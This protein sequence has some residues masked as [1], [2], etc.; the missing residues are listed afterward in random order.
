MCLD[1]VDRLTMRSRR[2]LFGLGASPLLLGVGS[3]CPPGDHPLPAHRV[4]GGGARGEQVAGAV[5]ILAALAA[6]ILLFR[7][8]LRDTLFSEQAQAHLALGTRDCLRYM[9]V[10]KTKL[11]WRLSV[12]PSTIHSAV[13]SHLRRPN[14]LTV[15]SRSEQQPHTFAEVLL[16]PKW[17]DASSMR[18]SG[19]TGEA[20][21]PPRPSN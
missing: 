1:H 10:S 16:L 14:H 4:P 8:T 11:I 13:V 5:A 2:R 21:T 18:A 7:T 6:G 15:C 19:T 12:S 9:D 3:G 17:R 20:K